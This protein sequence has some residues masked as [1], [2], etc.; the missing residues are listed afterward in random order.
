MTVHLA[1]GRQLC[2]EVDNALGCP[3]RP[4]DEAALVRKFVD[5]AGRA[6]RPLSGAA[7]RQLAA[8]ILTLEDCP[9]VGALFGDAPR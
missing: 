1:D 7:A 6:R 9:D 2:A 4:L 8:R 3:A 5:C